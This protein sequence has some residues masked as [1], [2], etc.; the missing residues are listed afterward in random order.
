MNNLKKTGGKWILVGL[1][2]M[3]M[4]ACGGE[5]AVSYSQDVKPIL[6][7]NCFECHQPGGRGEMAS[8]LNMESHE[9]LMKGA[10]FGPMII[11]GDPEGSNMV[12]LMEGR[13]DPSISMPHGKQQSIP[14][15]DIE[16][17]RLWIKQGAKNN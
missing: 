9:S 17:I 1:V 16:T 3:L 8:G 2:P 4:T 7:K 10:R 15:E 12:V 14:K 5:S 11:A 13:A 6:E